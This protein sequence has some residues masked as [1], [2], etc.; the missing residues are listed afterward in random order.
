MSV[1][2][3]M[4]MSVRA[5]MYQPKSDPA[6][7]RRRGN[8]DSK[9][10]HVTKTYQACLRNSE[11]SDPFNSWG[12]RRR[13]NVIVRGFEDVLFRLQDV[14]SWRATSTVCC[15]ADQPIH[16]EVVDIEFLKLLHG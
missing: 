9:T 7:T 16:T 12:T 4:I 8:G 6:G 14:I 10:R 11:K 1:M 3:V 5:Q 15:T 13:E 2:T